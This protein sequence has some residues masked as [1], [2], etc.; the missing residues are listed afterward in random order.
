[1]TETAKLIELGNEVVEKVLL[2]DP[3]QIIAITENHCQQAAQ[4][5][6]QCAGDVV[7]LTELLR[8]K[9]FG[10]QARPCSGHCHGLW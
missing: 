1:M 3:A 2:G 9:G 10:D 7:S 8:A 6:V 4:V 5:V